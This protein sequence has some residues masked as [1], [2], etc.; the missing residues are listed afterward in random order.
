MDT[1]L[2]LTSYLDHTLAEGH[3]LLAASVAAP[4][5]QIAACP[6]WTNTGLVECDMSVHTVVKILLDTR[7][8]TSPT[9]RPTPRSGAT[10]SSRDILGAPKPP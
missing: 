4:D 3:A 1:R 9:T 6:A 10:R 2:D 5:A 7:S 8:I